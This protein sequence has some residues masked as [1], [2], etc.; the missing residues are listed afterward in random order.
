MCSTTCLYVSARLYVFLGRGFLAFV[1][2]SKRVV[3]PKV[4]EPVCWA[5]SVMN[6]Q[7]KNKP[8]LKV[9]GVDKGEN[10]NLLARASKRSRGRLAYVKL[11][12]E[13]PSLS[14][15]LAPPSSFG[16]I[17]LRWTHY[18]QVPP[19][20][21]THTLTVPDAAEVLASRGSSVGHVH[22]H[23][24]SPP[25]G[26]QDAHPGRGCSVSPA[27]LPCSPRTVVL[28][29]MR[30]PSWCFPGDIWEV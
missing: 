1:G 20:V 26:D 9:A 4:F 30:I 10:W 18:N 6:D 19:W 5:L 16:F 8:Q 11:N 14:P 17:T 7:K 25:A 12:P 27:H 15:S 2:F 28:P 24:Q 23:E 21:Q 22:I 3:S 29:L 13:S